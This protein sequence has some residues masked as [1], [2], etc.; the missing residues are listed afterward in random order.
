MRFFDGG[1][2]RGWLRH[3]ITRRQVAGSNPHEI[4]GFFNWPNPSSRTMVLG[5]TQ[6]LMEMSTRNLPGG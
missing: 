2:Q 6:P 5:P 1:R 4:T 3:Y